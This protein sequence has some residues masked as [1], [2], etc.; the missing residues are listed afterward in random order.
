M[1]SKEFPYL[2]F[3]TYIYNVNRQSH[4]YRSE[5]LTLYLSL[6]QEKGKKI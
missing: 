4:Y 1:I 6:F 3:I 2:T 5:L